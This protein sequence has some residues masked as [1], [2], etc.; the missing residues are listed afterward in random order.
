[1]TEP[2]EK[3]YLSRPVMG[4]LNLSTYVQVQSLK[5]YSSVKKQ[6]EK[7]QMLEKVSRKPKTNC[8][9]FQE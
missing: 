5:A 8:Q 2:N 4:C 9:L 6:T 7:I 1:M 3:I